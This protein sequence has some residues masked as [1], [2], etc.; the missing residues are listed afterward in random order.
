MEP[1]QPQEPVNAAGMVLEGPIAELREREVRLLVESAEQ[2]GKMVPD[3]PADR[4]RLIDAADDLREAFL[5]VTIIGE[6]N[7]GKSTF[8]NALL[9]EPLLPMGITPTTNVIEVIRYAPT[10]V[11]K[12]TMRGDSVREWGHPNTGSAGVAIVDTPGTGSVFKKHEDIAKSF[13][14]R[15]DLVIFLISAKWAFAETE[16]LYLELAKGYGK[17]IIVVVNQSDLLDPKELNEVKKFVQQQ[18][19]QLLNLRPPLFMVSAK[20]ALQSAKPGGL[21]GNLAARREDQG[22]EDY[23]MDAVRAHLREVFEQ[24]PPA[25]QKLLTRLDLLRS[26]V[27]RHHTAIQG[28]LSLIG[29]DTDAAEALRR[30]IE[31]QAANLDRQL[32]GALDEVRAVLAGVQERG[33]RFVE[34][35]INVI[36]AT[37]RGIDRAKLAEE[38]ERDVLGDALTRIS[39]AQEHYV[40]ALVDGSRAYWRGV[41]DRLG[42]LDALLREESVGM[43]A[44]TYADQRAALQSALT[45]ANIEMKGYTDNKVIASIQ[46]HFDENVRGFTY[47]AVGSVGGV[48]A[49]IVSLAT[50]GALALYPL[51]AIGFTIGLPVTVA[52]GLLALRFWRKAVRDARKQLEGQIRE[53]EDSYRQALTRLTNDERNRLL[54]YGKQIL[55]P[56]FSQLQELAGRYR[57]QQGQLKKFTASADEIGKMLGALEVDGASTAKQ[58]RS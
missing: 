42:K 38:F 57:D 47:S 27:A 3:G 18:I 17:K 54:Q 43:D 5:M 25:K 4:Q 15:S 26:V 32:T 22:V 7:S 13:L 28:R 55:S 56:V 9:G 44:A 6:F 36:R 35:H 23:G 14:H 29:Q 2:I 37:L 20:K 30:E 21:F 8:V 46:S 24:V 40:N 11:N 10:V 16:R 50:P 58:G 1:N 48:V 53:L 45:L 12:P 51:A 34:K 49:V 52:G 31:L 39:S 33:D 41:I 19:D